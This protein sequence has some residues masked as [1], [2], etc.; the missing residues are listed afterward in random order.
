MLSMAA[1]KIVVADDNEHA[2]ELMKE[3]IRTDNNFLGR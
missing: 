3:A 2:V 1:T